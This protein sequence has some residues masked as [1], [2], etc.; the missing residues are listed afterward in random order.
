[1]YVFEYAS[2]ATSIEL[3]VD[4]TI[5]VKLSNF[6]YSWRDGIREGHNQGLRTLDEGRRERSGEVWVKFWSSSRFWRDWGCLCGEWA[7]QGDVSSGYYPW[8]LL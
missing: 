5:Y 6:L 4:V 8:W 1:M 2:K 3:Y 7:P